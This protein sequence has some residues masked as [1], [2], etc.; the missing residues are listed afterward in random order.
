[1]YSLYCS[2]TCAVFLRVF[3][4]IPLHLPHILLPLGR[5][6]NAYFVYFWFSLII[7]LILWPLHIKFLSTTT[8]PIC[9]FSLIVLF[10]SVYFLI[11]FSDVSFLRMLFY[12]LYL[13]NITYISC[14]YESLGKYTFW[15]IFVFIFVYISLFPILL[16]QFWHILLTFFHFIINFFAH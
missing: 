1:M 8:D 16:L 13:S 11:I 2:S 7:H 3:N 14:L 4:S 15:F 9:K 6:S 10:A 5:A 12:F